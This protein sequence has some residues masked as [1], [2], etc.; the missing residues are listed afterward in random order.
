MNVPESVLYCWYLYVVRLQIVDW[1]CEGFS[2]VKV[3][4]KGVDLAV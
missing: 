2:R 4:G 3:K 1:S